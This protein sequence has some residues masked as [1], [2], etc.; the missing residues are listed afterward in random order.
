[1]DQLYQYILSLKKQTLSHNL[2]YVIRVNRQKPRREKNLGGPYLQLKLPGA[3]GF[4][5]AAYSPVGQ[6]QPM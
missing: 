3:P 4:S 1:M 2:P 5:Q 6:A